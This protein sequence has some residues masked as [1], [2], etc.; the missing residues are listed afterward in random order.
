MINMEELKGLVAAR[1]KSISADTLGWLAV[2][3]MHGAT[4]PP[5]VGLL[6]GVSDKM[7]SADVVMFLWSALI[8]MF[9]KALITKDTLNVVTIGIG[10][11]IQS[12]LLGLLAFK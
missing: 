11:A 5:V 12:G 7:P 3:F 9:A 8:L 10:F 1:F 6:L 2:L 4:I